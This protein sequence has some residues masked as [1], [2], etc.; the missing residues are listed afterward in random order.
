MPAGR[1]TL[2]GFRSLAETFE[3]GCLRL[4]EEVGQHWQTKSAAQIKEQA[5]KL[6]ELLSKETKKS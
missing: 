3:Q 5:L 4:M 6:E 1:V 2:D